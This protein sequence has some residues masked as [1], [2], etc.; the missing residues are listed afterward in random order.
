MTQQNA[1]NE[2]VRSLILEAKAFEAGK[3]AAAE[4]GADV[5]P[6]WSAFL[7]WTHRYPVLGAEELWLPGSYA[8]RPR[9]RLIGEVAVAW[10]AFQSGWDCVTHCDA[11]E[12]HE[13]ADHV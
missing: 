12:A 8:V 11:I 13:V 4:R 1:T 10:A 7:D 6:S 5:R 2:A 3:R 9:S